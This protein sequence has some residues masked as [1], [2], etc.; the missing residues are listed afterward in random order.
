[1]TA[2]T[3]P[4]NERWATHLE[5]SRN[6][7]RVPLDEAAFMT[8][9]SGPHLVRYDLDE[10][11]GA[12][13]RGVLP[14][15]PWSMWRYRELLPVAAGPRERL[16]LGE[17]GTPLVRLGRAAP[18]GVEVWFKEES[19]NPTGS[20]KARGLSVA[21]N[22]AVELGAPGV[23][24]PSAGNAAMASAAY[25]AAAGLPCT[26]AIP[27]DTPATIGERCRLLGAEVISGGRNLAESG[28]ILAERKSGFWN[29]AT[30]NEPYRLEG[31]KSMGF[32]LA[33]QFDGR[34]PDWIFYPTGGGT[35]LIAMAKAF[36]ELE[37]LGL[38][39]RRRPRLV[40]VQMAGCA[41][42][43][44]AFERGDDKAEPW[45]DPRTRAWGLRV[46]S[47]RGDFLIL[48]AVRASGGLAVAVEEEALAGAVERLAREEGQWVGPEGAAC[49]LAL[50]K[51]VEEKTVAA[52]ERVVLFQTGHPASYL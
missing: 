9:E 18:S 21:I 30:L 1:M 43:V 31:K 27:E 5:G 3:S 2:A 49:F 14:G 25:A 26:V 29:I 51:L 39:G 4:L 46:P 47:A 19:G 17:G 48:R 38:L 22:R 37:A 8:P 23:E 10:D 6:G 50:E 28:A 24:L 12:A 20:F 42:I 34:L 7:E 11:K 33:E 44:R 52:G 45:R 13:L 40:S 35:G 32:E 36:D 41:P 15:R 16:D